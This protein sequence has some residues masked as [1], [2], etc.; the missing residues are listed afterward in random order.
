MN[1]GSDHPLYLP[2]KNLLNLGF[3]GAFAGKWQKKADQEQL[4]LGIQSRSTSERH[5]FA[6]NAK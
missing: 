1:Q 5:P 2:A 6:L 4:E 3:D